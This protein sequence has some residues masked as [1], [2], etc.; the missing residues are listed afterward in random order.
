MRPCRPSS[1]CFLT[2]PSSMLFLGIMVLTLMG[3]QSAAAQEGRAAYTGMED[4]SYLIPQT[5]FVGDEGR[6]VLP[7]GSAYRGLDPMVLNVPELL[8]RTRDILIRRIE[9]E[10][11]GGASRLFV[12]FQA[13]APGRLELPLIE[14]GSFEFAGL[15]VFIS[16]V[17][18]MEEGSP[19]LS[20]T[21]LPLAVPGTAAVVYGTIVA[22]ILFTAA[23][24]LAGLRGIPGFRTLRERNR[25]RRVIRYIR[26]FLLRM[27]N[28]VSKD[29][30]NSALLAESLSLVNGQFRDFL[31]FFS[32][33]P[34][35]TF[36]P[37]EFLSLNIVS[38]GTDMMDETSP[39]LSPGFLRALFLRWDELRF[40]GI[41]P[42][43]D[44]VLAALGEAL[45]FVNS[46]DAAE[47]A[48]QKRGG[49]REEA[50]LAAEGVS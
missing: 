9:L 29:P 34:C 36:V 43:G 48:I 41:D 45:S 38:G 18:A 31:S 20:N 24:V 21:A 35:N 33:A 15:S 19:V 12:D 44:A 16:S 25:R 6:L 23:A 26:R 8:P 42:Q 32:G 7:L 11:K 50:V 17:L 47:R 5:V 37:G 27:K 40:S 46:F 14:I 39:P 28:R 13:Y 49:H 1:V 10:N 30:G 2:G 22:L 3:P 4:A